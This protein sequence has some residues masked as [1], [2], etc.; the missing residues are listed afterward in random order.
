MSWWARFLNQFR[1]APATPVSALDRGFMVRDGHCLKW[2][3]ARL[4]IDVI[5]APGNPN[6]GRYLEEA[7]SATAAWNGVVVPPRQLFM[8]PT[9]AA[10]PQLLEAF[11]DSTKRKRL[12]GMVLIKAIDRP[13]HTWG[14]DRHLAQSDFHYD[15]RTGEIFNVIVTVPAYTQAI[16]YGQQYL[17]Q[18]LV[19]ECGHILGLD[20]DD[21][22]ESIMWPKLRAEATKALS[23]DVARIRATYG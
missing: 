12:R 8:R 18:M 21:S 2:D 7:I 16:V 5:L 22:P 20:H 15:K 13:A 4:P 19:H 3:R 10:A 1:P 14:T 17:Y 23:G 6:A 9:D 11:A